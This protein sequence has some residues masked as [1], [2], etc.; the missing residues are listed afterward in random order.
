VGFG[1]ETCYSQ[2][3]LR[4]ARLAREANPGC[5]IVAGGSHFPYVA[6]EVLPASEIDA[7]VIGE[8][9]FTFLELVQQVLSGTPDLSRVK[10]LAHVRDGQ[11]CL[12]EP[13]PIIPNLDDLPLPD[14]ELMG[15]ENYGKGGVLWAFPGAAPVFHSRGCFSGC[16]FCAFW[17]TESQWLRNAAGDL[18]PTPTYRTKSVERTVEEMDLLYHKYG[19]RFFSWI[20]GTFNADS[21]WNDRW[22]EELLRRGWGIKWFAFQRADCLAR[23]EAQGILEKMVR[24]GMAYTIVGVE[25]HRDEDFR[26]LHKVNYD[27]RMLHDACTMMRRKYP[28]VFLHGTFI[29]GLEDDGRETLLDLS[30]YA[31]DLG[32][33]FASFHFLS[34]APGTLLHKTMKSQGK[35]AGLD[36]SAMDWFTPLWPT[37]RLDIPQLDALQYTMMK[38]FMLRKWGFLPDLGRASRQKRRM[39]LWF[40]RK[41]LGFMWSEAKHGLLGQP[42]GLTLQPPAWYDA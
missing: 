34:P 41:G 12:N 2:E 22:S 13:R 23:D 16:T 7:A 26:A 19:R 24:A 42:R 9:E 11:V 25:R 32:L 3:G 27:T 39:Y 1:D 15:F 40:L 21:Q 10:G 8:G 14:Y 30:D 29:I 36:Y 33:D 28:Q 37:R 35:T 17:P 6:E 20:D 31:A 5:L 4:V 38:R 18:V